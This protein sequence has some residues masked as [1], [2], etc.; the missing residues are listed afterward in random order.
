[1][2]C[3]RSAAAAGVVCGWVVQ[4]LPALQLVLLPAHGCKVLF[5]TM[6]FLAFP[7]LGLAAGH[8]LR[9]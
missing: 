4:S 5:I 6:C 2:L 9:D 8:E 3:L 7:R 1:V